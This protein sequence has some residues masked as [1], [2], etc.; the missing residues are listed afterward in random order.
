MWKT[1]RLVRTEKWVAYV[2]TSHDV[3]EDKD[4][5]RIWMTAVAGGDALR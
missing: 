5:K 4:K 1:L 3:K 2:V